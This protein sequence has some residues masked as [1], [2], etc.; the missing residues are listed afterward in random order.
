M[1]PSRP[2]TAILPFLVCP[3]ILLSAVSPSLPL[4]VPD[5]IV[6]SGGTAQ[7]Q[8]FLASPAAIDSGEVSLDLDPAVFGGIVAAGVFSVTGDQVG[9]AN[10]QDRHVD[11]QFN[12]AT[13]GVGRL[14]NLP[15]VTV[16]VPVVSTAAAGAKSTI[17][18]NSST[19]QPASAVL[20]VG[21]ALSVASV[22][23]GGGSLATG[24]VVTIVGTGFAASTSV[25]IDGAAIASTQ[26]V[27]AHEIDLTLA[28]PA[29][30]TGKRVLVQNAD[31]SL[32]AFYPA[33][34][35]SYVQRPTSGGLATIQPIFPQQLYQACEPAPFL[36][37]TPYVALQNPLQQ[38]VDV[39]LKT[40]IEYENGN[41]VTGSVLTLPPYSIAVVNQYY[42]YYRPFYFLIVP[43]API[44]MVQIDAVAGGSL[45]NPTTVPVLQPFLQVDGNPDVTYPDAEGFSIPV[46]W[47]AVAGG[48]PPAPQTFDVVLVDLPAPFTLTASTQSGGHWLSVSPQQGTTC[49]FDNCAAASKVVISVDPTSLVPGTYNGSLSITTQG[50]GTQPTVIPVVFNVFA[51]PP[52][53]VSQS[54]LDLGAAPANSPPINRPVQITSTAGPIAFSVSVT[55]QS[56]QVWLSA[57]PASGTTPATLTITA[58]PA[59]LPAPGDSGTVTVRGPANVQV[60]SVVWQLTPLQS[61]PS[62]AVFP[63]S[64][65]F[66]VQ[67]GQPNPAV[68]D[69]SIPS[70]PGLAIST[71]TN[72]GGKWLSAPIQ[73]SQTGIFAAVTVDPT[74]LAPG[75]YRGTVI[76][77]PASSSTLNPGL[78]PVTFYVWASP[79]PITV[80]PSALN[81][82]TAYNGATIGIATG[83]ISI[84]F[85]IATSGDSGLIIGVQQAETSGYLGFSNAPTPTTATIGAYA[86]LPGVYHGQVTITAP[87]GSSNTATV[88]ITLTVSAPAG[89][90]PLAT[91]VVN[92]ASQ[93]AGAVSPGEIVTIFGQAI[94]PPA[95]AGFAL[96]PD[97]KVATNLGGTQ[98]FFDSIAAPVLYA[99]NTQVNAIVP[100]PI[101][102]AT[103]TDVQVLFNG[104]T[105]P[106]G[107]IPVADAEP[108]VFTQNSTGLGEAAV[109][110]EDSSLNAFSNAAARGSIIQIF[111]T[112]EGQTVPPSDTGSV[113]G[114]DTKVPKLA[115]GV[116]IGGA[117][118]TITYS[119]SAPDAISG[120]FQVNAVVPPGIAPGAAV[121]LVLKVGDALSPANTTIAVK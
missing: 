27:G 102:G 121:P 68:Q 3:G 89:A 98:V 39:E 51:G 16:T 96:G 78:I 104:S 110:N 61:P 65:V 2:L 118:A 44:R 82:T 64:L 84:P 100:F 21:G 42:E 35:G 14:P 72:D 101:G 57:S 71:Q 5:L 109:L 32:V 67:T 75:A 48:T 69:V 29:D 66:T 45:V 91:S 80:T 119:A 79:P 117:P 55:T 56:G 77:T 92:A 88:P 15:V 60:I 114:T 22:S 85:D 95:P 81:L 31:A 24:A 40:V 52:I 7:I 108:A 19:F 74:G 11:V 107:G 26:F 90:V 94:G 87:P 36:G 47:N 43:T 113:T 58:N 86:T 59:M 70:T 23:P 120:L 8:I 54:S 62:V 49:T 115:V 116:T 41:T 30:L 106:A 50:S 34:R 97:G 10:I 1:L 63:T 83:N 103:V 37:G 111:T 20:T 12:S 38:S 6:P 18:V 112:G 13:G 99:S 28:A 25:A 76:V 17:N 105:I 93:I 9:T 46:V 53:L 73:S 33:L 4:R